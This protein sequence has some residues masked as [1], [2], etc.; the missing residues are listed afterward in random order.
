MHLIAQHQL[1]NQHNSIEDEFNH[2][3]TGVMAAHFNHSCAPNAMVLVD[4]A[5]NWAYVLVRPVKKGEEVLISWF[6]FP[7]DMKTEPRKQLL[8]EHKGLHCVCL[9]CIGAETD[10]AQ[11]RIKFDEDFI[12][13]TSMAKKL[14]TESDA[15]EI[16]LQIE[17]CVALLNKY[18]T[19]NWCS[20]LCDAIMAF[21]NAYCLQFN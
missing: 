16:S 21:T 17:K 8:L 15:N 11:R 6:P 10:W 14:T 12:S 3:C 9:R 13:I 4:G 1:I 5:A 20:E 18:G 2:S 19:I 7:L